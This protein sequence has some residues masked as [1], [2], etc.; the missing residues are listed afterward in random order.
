MRAMS[1]LAARLR[2]PAAAVLAVTVVAA[3]GGGGDDGPEASAAA[4]AAGDDGGGAVASEPLMEA[5]SRRAPI[6][7]VPQPANTDGRLLASNCFQ[8]HGTGGVGGFDSIRGKEAGE[9]AE[10]LRKSAGSS[11]MAAHVQ[12]YTREQLKAIVAY[13]RQR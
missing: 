11:I 3:C 7:R 5:A 13:L 1:K 2:G 6:V 10:F 9:A 4:S 12:G 8:C